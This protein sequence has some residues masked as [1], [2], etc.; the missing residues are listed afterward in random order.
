MASQSDVDCC[1]QISNFSN[2]TLVMEA[3]EPL[4]LTAAATTTGASGAADDKPDTG[5]KLPDIDGDGDAATGD[6]TSAAV[7]K[8]P[9]AGGNERTAT[10]DDAA[11][12]AVDKPDAGLKRDTTA[13][14]G[15]NTRARCVTGCEHPMPAQTPEE[16]DWDKDLVL[17]FYHQN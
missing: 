1:S 12:P 4:V 16:S 11:G 2:E 7:D 14:A 3:I 17:S 10:G 9:D 15:S 13:A 8:K 5:G 6:A